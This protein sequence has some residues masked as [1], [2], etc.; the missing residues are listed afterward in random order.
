MFSVCLCIQIIC[1]NTSITFH[2][3]KNVHGTCFC[4]YEYG[5]MPSEKQTRHSALRYIEG[6]ICLS[7]I[8]S[9]TNNNELK[10]WFSSSLSSWQMNRLLQF[11][12][13][14]TPNQTTWFE[15][16]G[17]FPNSN[18]STTQKNRLMSWPSIIS[19]YSGVSS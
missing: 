11:V 6:P 2:V 5:T 19:F 13:V 8:S 18:L 3:N 1:I 7:C 12:Y 4:S 15:I 10:H 14:V 17:L 16:A 9:R